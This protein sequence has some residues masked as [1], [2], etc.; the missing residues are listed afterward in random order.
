MQAAIR[1]PGRSRNTTGETTPTK[2]TPT[3]VTII[4]TKKGFRRIPHELR[5]NAERIALLQKLVS[6]RKSAAVIVE[7]LRT[8]TGMKFTRNGVL[9]KIHRLKLHMEKKPDIRKKPERRKKATPA[10]T[11]PF[12]PPIPIIGTPA[13]V[14]PMHG[15][16]VPTE[17]MGLTIV[18]LEHGQCRWPTT[19]INA[20]KTLFCGHPVMEGRSWCVHHAK[21]GYIAPQERVR[22]PYRV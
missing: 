5:W 18:E 3:I 14:L 11:A 6:E 21:I 13:N 4:P 20:V 17:S 10:R 9:G 19:P 16:T 15:I 2:P 1:E 12:Q 8:Q 22:R 7:E